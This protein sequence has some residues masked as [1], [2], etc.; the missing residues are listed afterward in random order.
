MKKQLLV[1]GI[2][3]IS[4]VFLAQTGRLWKEVSQK[5]NSEIL[6]NKTN[7]INPRTYS[8]DF[9]NLK[10]AL[11]KASKRFAV[12]GKSDVIISFPNS[13]GNIEDFKVRE[14]SNFAPELAAQYPDIKSYVGV[15]VED[16]S[17]TVYFSI[18]PL[19]LSSMEIYANKSAVFIEP[20]TKDLSTYVVYKKSD[21]KAS[22][23]KFECTVL[24][25]AQKGIDN[26]NLTAR[27]NADDSKLR[28]F[29]LALSCTGE[30]TAFFGGTVAGALA[31]MNNTMT[32]VNGVFE[33]DFSARMV[34]IANTTSVIYTNAATD[35]YTGN[36]NL[37]LQQTLTANI[38][39]DNYDIGH[40]FNAAGNNGNAGC[41]GCVCVNPATNTTQAKGSGFTQS[42][43]PVGDSFDIDFVAHEMGH[44][45]G[46]NHTFSMSIEA[47][48]V[49]NVEPGSGS[50]IMG[51]A[52]ITDQNVVMNSDPFFHAISIQQITNNIKTKTCPVTTNTGNTIPT[53]DAGLDYIIP[54]GTP[55]KLTGTGT[56]GDGDALTYIWEQ[57]D[58]ASAGQTG[59]N[60][61]ATA[62]KA[63]GPTFRSYTPQTVP[64]RYFPSL[65]RTLLGATTTSS[66]PLTSSPIV[67][68]ALSN[69]ARTYNF[70]FTTRDNRAG[71]SGNN[72]DDMVVTVNAG[73]G[74]FT[75]T[76][77]N[78]AGVVWTEGQSYAITWN[79]ANTTA[80][81]VSTPNVTILL[82]KD[83]G[84][85]WP[86]VLVASAPN[87]GTYNYTV[88]GGLGNTVNTARIM[89]KGINNIFF[90]V[91]LQNF[92]IN[93]SAVI[94]PPTP[95]P[96]TPGVAPSPVY[97]GLMIYPVPSNDGIVYIK[98]D[99]PRLVPQAPYPFSYTIYAMD[100]KLV[101]PKRNRLFFSEHLEKIDLRGVPS[102][103]YMIEVDLAGEKIVKKL[104]MLNK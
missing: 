14:N 32:R 6:E 98:L 41:I 88:P 90:N 36:L 73:A 64:V 2:F 56:D 17:S 79:V 81:P 48:G 87:N 57:M 104:L 101:I 25:V 68:E 75:V 84:L 49:N 50:T 96:G 95:T 99:F 10:N 29:R 80:A 89:V 34:I 61:A 53:A 54:R 63:S 93:S 52:G 100:G 72:S 35:P 21:K 44:Q 38:G 23:D 16:P 26:S 91:N 15:G 27:P 4:N 92:T 67:V 83:G 9:D 19:G 20:Y 69:V 1:M 45:F 22:L 28:T 66:P 12:R 86:T 46:G 11:V 60:S 51:Y 82:S 47:G 70:R 39:N 40:V 78:T 62:T 7:I 30:Y 33:K 94:I 8:L 77:Q 31:A 65:D 43:A 59:A 24:D 13:N 18:S 55:F 37:Q 85:T 3:L 71:G 76:S 103:T 5:N 74:P 58:P 97:D 102:G 42:T